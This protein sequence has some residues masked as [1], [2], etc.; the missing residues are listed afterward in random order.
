MGKAIL[1]ACSLLILSMVCYSNSNAQTL[2]ISMPSPEFTPKGDIT[3]THESQ[4]RAWQPRPTYNAFNFFTYGLGFSTEACFSTYNTTFDGSGQP[5]IGFGFKSSPLL[6]Q[7]HS[8]LAKWELRPTIGQMTLVSLWRKAE[9]GSWVYATISCR[10]PKVKT[11]IS[12]GVSYG[13]PLLFGYRR[14]LDTRGAVRYSGSPTVGAIVTLEQPLYKGLSFWMDWM[15]GGHEY[16]VLAPALAYN[17]QNYGILVGYKLPNNSLSG[18][19][20]I[21]VEIML[22][23]HTKPKKNASEGHSEHH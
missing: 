20:A 11:R 3:L 15:S 10:F 8:R 12:V 14:M 21:I 18:D 5:L 6:F 17:Y 22:H 13:S 1:V 16:G 7:K 4:F 9:V 23:L 19:N 2:V